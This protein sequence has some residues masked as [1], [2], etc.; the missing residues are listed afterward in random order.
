M[1]TRTDKV[2]PKDGIYFK[3]FQELAGLGGNVQFLKNEFDSQFVF[4]LKNQM[5]FLV[6]V[7]CL[8]TQKHQMRIKLRWRIRQNQ[9]I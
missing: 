6:S 9:P 7:Q 3:I 2:F 4:E 1:D 8:K 5:V